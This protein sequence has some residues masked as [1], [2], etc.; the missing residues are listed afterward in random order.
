MIGETGQRILFYL[1][2][3]IALLVI[4]AAG[5]GI[6]DVAIYTPMTPDRMLPGAVSQDII[7]LA[8]ALGLVACL[9]L[10]RRGWA[11]AW[12]IW[13][14]LMAYMFYAYALYAFEGVYNAFYLIYVAILGGSVYA[15]IVFFRFADLSRLVYATDMHPPRRVLAALFM[16]L[17]VLFAGLW[18]SILVPAMAQ[19]QAPDGGT[20]FVLDL[21]F[22]LPLLVIESVLLWRGTKLGDVL[23]LPLVIKVATLGI[24]VFVGTLL[25]PAFDLKLALEDVAVYAVL[26]FGP[27][28]FVPLFTRGLEIR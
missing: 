26:G 2:A 28:V 16:V 14:G 15:M 8:A 24:S 4:V 27:L 7:S 20:I 9:V 22:V 11:P 25:G 21:A 1:T 3:V 6:G 5:F 12:P 23:A 10:A 17:V 19:R 18:L 13:L